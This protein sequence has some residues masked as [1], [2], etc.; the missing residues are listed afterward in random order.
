MRKTIKLLTILF[1]LSFSFN[2][3]NA[4]EII[5][6]T[7][8]ETK[9]EQER[10]VTRAEAFIFFAD[11]F[12]NTPESY[13]YIWLKQKNIIKWSELEKALKVLVYN[14]KLRNNEINIFANKELNSYVFYS[15]AKN[16]L[17]IEMTLD[18]EKLS[19]TNTKTSDL[20]FIKN[21][22]IQIQE[23]KQRYLEY[24]AFNALWNKKD[25]FNDVFITILNW[26]YNN[27]N[28]KEEDLIY[29]AI[30]W[31]A[32]WT[33]DEHTVYFPPTESRSFEENLE[34]EY[35]W[36]GSY[37][38]LTSPWIVTITSPLPGWPAEKSWIK[39]WDIIKKVNGREV[40]R[41]NS[42]NEVVSW[43]KWPAW[44][45]VE[46]TISRW[47]EEIIINVVREKI[48][49]KNL[50]FEKSNNNTFLIKIKSFWSN[51]SR[52]FKEALDEVNKD[53]N[54]KK[55]VI[56]LRNNWGW[57]LDQVVE[58][59]SYV[60]EKWEKVAVVK[61]NW[62]EQTYR[63][64]WYDLLDL[65]KYEI[66]ILQNS[67][68]ASASEIMIWTLKDYFEIKTI[69]EKTYW[70][71]SVQT[72]KEYNDWSSFKYTIANWYTWWSL[73]WIDW[74]WIEP[75]LELELDIDKLNKD[76]IDNQLQ[77]AIYN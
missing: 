66:V 54:I 4:I 72:L 2:S 7:N 41:E 48:I 45:S 5:T 65:D 44:T 6:Q 21:T 68:T 76:W 53:S 30:E 18:Y 61:Y 10:E 19:K 12:S 8:I 52:D 47:S 50:E 51:V 39:W 42:L 36:I 58:M 16:I 29:S 74:I 71:W 46:L 25:I 24:Q 37:V 56:D 75:D 60:V 13:K 22:Y 62:I 14:D 49:I 17:D 9:I 26:H 34:W 11:F 59:L 27:Q 73:T 32:K 38:E 28:I 77:K 63:S 35:E 23:E 40:K 33:R 64:K 55:I 67:W 43:I 3:T 15:L 57:Y 70:K 69:W 31:L 20:R 1:I